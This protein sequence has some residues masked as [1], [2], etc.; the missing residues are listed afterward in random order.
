MRLL[1]AL[2]LTLWI[3]GIQ[4]VGALIVVAHCLAALFALVRH[5]EQREARLLVAQG[6]ITGLGYT[7]AATLLK[8]LVLLSWRQIA[9]FAAIFA[10]RTLLK[11]L[12][13]WE[14]QHLAS[15]DTS[16]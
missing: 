3:T 12:F 15:G 6:A 9:M 1:D 4:L 8:T 2:H 5:R 16:L 13:V 11:R 14:Q 10:L 7:L